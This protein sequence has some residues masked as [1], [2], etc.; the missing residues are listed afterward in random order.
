MAREIDALS[1]YSDLIC[2]RLGFTPTSGSTKPLAIANSLFR[3]CSGISC[4][5]QDIHEWIVSERR[6]D[7]K[8]T[9]SEEIKRKYSKIL[10]YG[11]KES[12]DA[13]KEV[14]FILE[15]VFNPDVTVFPSLPNSVIN[16]SS[17]WLV[18]S[19]LASE[20]RIGAFIYDI[21]NYNIDGKVSPAI[22]LIK[23]ALKDDDDDI[24]RI[25]KPIITSKP[26]SE[27]IIRKE[28]RS[29]DIILNK[30][31]EIIRQGFDNLAFNITYTGQ[32]QNSLLVL[33]RMTNYAVFAV[34]FYLVDINHSEYNEKRIPLLLDTGSG[35]GAVERASELC[36]IACKKSVEA[37]VINTLESIILE[38]NFIQNINNAE[39]YKAYIKKSIVLNT[40][41][42]DKMVRNAL[43]N[44]FNTFLSDGD[45]P[46]RAFARALQFAIF[47]FTYSKGTTP[48]DFLNTLGGKSG[49]IGPNGNATKFKRL[50]INRFLL[51]TI[52]LSTLTSDDLKDGIELRE[53]GKQL[54]DKYNILL[55]S[56]TDKDYEMLERMQIA[57]DA[58]EDLRGK[59][60]DNTKAMADMLITIGLAKRY[61]DGV[62][63]IRWGR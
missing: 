9:S 11:N 27:R 26:E 22:G 57:Q 56:D 34:Y 23:D 52:V 15:K 58:P 19:S 24:S 42:E 36:F 21:L 7:P 8:I 33:R 18:R 29:H 10:K 32:A 44:Y 4:N 30:S 51:E 39:E 53:L 50:M 3:T 25:L 43:L 61:A 13:I 41:N 62:T 59:L 35:L 54:R 40:R 16:I 45:K 55:G 46:I 20:G 17:G 5:I 38:E 48:S 37:F 31:K 2:E 14:R 47:T 28:P 12:V 49:L 6:S 63:I 60:A 1:G